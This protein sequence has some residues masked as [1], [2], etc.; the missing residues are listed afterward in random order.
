MT[1]LPETAVSTMTPE[2]LQKWEQALKDGTLDQ[3]SEEYQNSGID[4]PRLVHHSFLGKS[5]RKPSKKRKP[6]GISA[7]GTLERA[8]QG[9]R[10]YRCRPLWKEARARE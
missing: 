7:H 10:C 8:K 1:A 4:W 3:F 6:R 2:Q 5:H 9:C